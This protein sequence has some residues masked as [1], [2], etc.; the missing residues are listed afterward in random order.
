MEENGIYNVKKDENV[1]QIQ[2]KPEHFCSG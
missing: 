1:K 2:K